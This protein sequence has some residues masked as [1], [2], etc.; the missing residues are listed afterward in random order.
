LKNGIDIYNQYIDIGIS[1]T[2]EDRPQFQE[3]IKQA[4]D[5][6]IILV[7]KFDRFARKIE[8]SH[9]IKAYLKKHQVNVISITEPVED[10]PIGFF[11]EGL[12]ELLAEYYVR[13]LSKEVK[14]GLIERASQGFHTGT[15]PY[16]YYTVNGI[17]HIKQDEAEIVKLIYKLY[18][19]GMGCQKITLYLQENRVKTRNNKQFSYSK[20]NRILHNTKYIGM[21][22]Y[23][24]QVYKGTHDAIISESDFS[25]V[26]HQI[27]NRNSNTGRV[28]QR[29]VNFYKFHLLDVLYCGVC[30]YKM[31][32]VYRVNKLGTWQ[33]YSYI[34][35]R[36]QRCDGTCNHR[37]SY[38]SDILEHNIN[39]LI[40]NILTQ[41]KITAHTV[42]K[43]VETN[44][45]LELRIEKINTEIERAKKAYLAG[46]FELDE[47]NET[48][49][50]L[51]HEIKEIKQEI[52]QAIKTPNIDV[53]QA[54]N[55]YE[56][57]I[58]ETD[59]C[60][61]RTILQALVEKIIISPD[62]P[63]EVYFRG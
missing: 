58:N 43:P 50:N 9:R 33:R 37:K 59:I 57:Y 47:Y 35:N 1:G 18:L 24:G 62:K 14:K 52:K 63:P 39:M 27:K 19:D 48:K 26:Q 10:S 25:E 29:N 53:V 46:V 17:L 13:N 23:D 55:I 40:K 51:Q 20:V 22:E 8:L 45:M 28:M 16:G 56:K 31:R 38:K 44:N 11:Q 61:K 5:F 7:H 6:D 54:R 42:K 34:C 41:K 60:K 21:I 30:G 12:L 2:R 4:K 32:I 15:S 3:M 36:A 49:T